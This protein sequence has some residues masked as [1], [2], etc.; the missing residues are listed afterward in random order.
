MLTQNFITSL[1][2]SPTVP[3]EEVLLDPRDGSEE[4]GRVGLS[5]SL[6][7]EQL[8]DQVFEDNR[9]IEKAFFDPFVKDK[10]LIKERLAKVA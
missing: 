7:I 6:Q 1:R 2:R 4:V 10:T 9:E 8:D 5:Y 3:R